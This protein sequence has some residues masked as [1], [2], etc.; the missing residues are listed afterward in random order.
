MESAYVCLINWPKCEQYLLHRY[1]KLHSVWW[2]RF[3]RSDQRHAEGGPEDPQLR[4]TQ[5][6]NRET[7]QDKKI[8]K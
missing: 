2:L 1:A 3:P 6:V 4:V 8:N 7:A 5:L